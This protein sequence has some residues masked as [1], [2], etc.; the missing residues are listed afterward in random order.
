MIR[1]RQGFLIPRMRSALGW[2]LALLKEDL[3]TCPSTPMLLKYACSQGQ[4]SCSPLLLTSWEVGWVPNSAEG[5]Q[6]EGS[7]ANGPYPGCLNNKCEGKWCG[8]YQWEEAV[9]WIE[10]HCWSRSFFLHLQFTTP[11]PCTDKDTAWKSKS[12]PTHRHTYRQAKA[13]PHSPQCPDFPLAPKTTH[14]HM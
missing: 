11:T 2:G 6:A 7:T 12:F 13:L 4:G 8:H 1:C 5:M 14:W 3:G 9:N 10:E